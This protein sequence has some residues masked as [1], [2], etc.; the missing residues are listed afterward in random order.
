LNCGY[1]IATIEGVKRGPGRP[2]QPGGRA[3]E[4]VRLPSVLARVVRRYAEERGITMGEAVGQLVQR[5][6]RW[7]LV[8]LLGLAHDELLDRQEDLVEELKE[9]S[10]YTERQAEKLIEET[11]EGLGELHDE[12]AGGAPDDDEDDN[13]DEEDDEDGDEEDEED[14][15]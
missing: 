4:K 5:R 10:G 15:G 6:K 11:I 2:A 1:T 8:E 3:E 13:E 14:R 7:S 12:L 9:D